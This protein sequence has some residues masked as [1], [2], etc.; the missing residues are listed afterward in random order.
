MNDY[1][2]SQDV[3]TGRW[4]CHVKGFPYVPCFGS[5]CESK[6]EALEYAKM[7]N[8]LPHKVE[9]IENERRAK[10]GTCDDL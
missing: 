9:K 5:I 8:G 6:A 3:K 4:Y 1:I 2:V 10:Y 7:Y